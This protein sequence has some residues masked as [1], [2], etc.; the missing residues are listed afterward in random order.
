MNI[1]GISNSA[2]IYGVKREAV[3]GKGWDNNDAGAEDTDPVGRNRD[4]YIPSEEDEPIGLYK[5]SEDENGDPRIEYDA[6]KAPDKKKEAPENGERSEEC[7][8]NTD[9]VDT[10]IKRLR[11]KAKEL[12]RQINDSE[13]EK[14]ALLEKQL[15]QVE[16]ELKN[17]DNDSYRRRHTVFS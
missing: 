16:A 3:C 4:E 12:S 5:M 9:K 7:T 6:P 1:S 15:A 17:K 14:R 11:E 2:D 8:G 13:G 10:E